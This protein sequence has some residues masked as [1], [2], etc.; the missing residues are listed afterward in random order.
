MGTI[1]KQGT[2]EFPIIDAFTIDKDNVQYIACNYCS[3]LSKDNEEAIDHFDDVHT[4]IKDKY[5]PQ[6]KLDEKTGRYWLVPKYDTIEHVIFDVSVVD[7][8]IHFYGF[9]IYDRELLTSDEQ[10]Y[11]RHDSQTLLWNYGK[12]TVVQPQNIA[13]AVRIKKRKRKYVYSYNVGKAKSDE[14]KKALKEKYQIE[15]EDIIMKQNKKG[16]FAIF[17]YR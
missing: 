10:K 7:Y 1:R 17:Y 4:D 3:H 8:Y 13:K 14:V 11:A 15:E 2:K 9:C 5:F 16:N 12:K 6:K